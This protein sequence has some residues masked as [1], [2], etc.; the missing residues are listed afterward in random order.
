MPLLPLLIEIWLIIEIFARI[1][2]RVISD[3][4]VKH[5]RY[6][7]K[8]I[9]VIYDWDSLAFEKEPIIVGHASW[10][11]TY[12]EFFGESRLPTVEETREFIAEYEASHLRIKNIKLCKLRK[13]MGLPIVLGVS[14]LWIPMKRPIQKEVAAHFLLI[15]DRSVR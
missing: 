10:Y 3:W 9:R 5:F 12:T 7:G 11:F 6:V 14:T 2:K 1:H 8:K 13:S 4:G 15:I